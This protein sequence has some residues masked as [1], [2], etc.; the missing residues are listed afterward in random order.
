MYRQWLR[1]HALLW[2][3]CVLQRAVS[4]G[5]RCVRCELKAPGQCDACRVTKENVCACG[6]AALRVR[7]LLKM[8][9]SQ[10]LARDI[11]MC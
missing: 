3:L 4:D 6:A 8:R 10:N 5:M 7:T 11:L 2:V 9:L 1:T